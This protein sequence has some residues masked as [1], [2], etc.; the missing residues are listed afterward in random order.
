MFIAQK[1]LI[2]LKS[3]RKVLGELQRT[4]FKSGHH[5]EYDGQATFQNCFI[6]KRLEIAQQQ[7]I[8]VSFM[9]ATSRYILG[10]F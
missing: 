3:R 10:F 8:T 6:I 4:S 2:V 7:S 9:G 5:S 1:I